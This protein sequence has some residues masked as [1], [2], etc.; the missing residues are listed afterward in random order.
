M[1]C[2]VHVGDND[3]LVLPEYTKMTHE[4]LKDMG[5]REQVYKTYPGLGHSTSLDVSSVC[6]CVCVWEGEV[7]RRERR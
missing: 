6:V 4:G 1:Y 7:G 2:C 3:P 5:F